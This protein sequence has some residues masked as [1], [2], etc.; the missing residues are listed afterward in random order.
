MKF[1]TIL[2]FTFILALGMVK[3]QEPL[4]LNFETKAHKG[5]ILVHSE[6]M[7][8]LVKGFPSMFEF[9]GNIQ[10]NGTQYWQQD[11]LNPEVGIS[12]LYAN[13]KNPE[14]LGSA[15][16][17]FP[18]I[19]FPFTKGNTVGLSLR[20]GAGI[21]YLTKKYD[22][23]A[24]HKNN[25]IGSNL[26]GAVN[27]V[28][29]NQIF[30]TDK[31]SLRNGIAFTHFSN[32]AYRMPNLGVN[33]VTLNSGLNYSFGERQQKQF[34]KGKVPVLNPVRI[35]FLATGG[36]KSLFV[37]H[38]KHPTFTLNSTIEKFVSHKS[39][40]GIGLDVSYNRALRE[41][42]FILDGVQISNTDL[43]QSGMHFSYALN[44]DKLSIFINKGLYLKQ[45]DSHTGIFYHR[46]G[47]RYRIN[48]RFITNISLKSHFGVA[49]YFE[50][51]LGYNFRR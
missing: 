24:N 41:K 17:V 5:F 2:I 38:P 20:V 4:S 33:I 50:Y 34:L 8:H 37:L 32:G 51:G 29:E 30:I 28:L 39:S 49:D 12:V 7:S 3:A 35:S 47:V 42:L 15:I 23:L 31:L 48:H 9:T 13:L 11:Y 10:T 45:V 46:I 40:F 16:S 26:N 14:Q 44:V 25:A 43:I 6:N 22:R 19:N 18:H 1:N 27:F 36:V 21:A